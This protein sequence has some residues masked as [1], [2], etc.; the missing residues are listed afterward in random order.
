MK[1]I[2]LTGGN[3]F[4]GRNI[5]EQL[6]GEYNI[7]A[8]NSAELDLLDAG[9][10]AAYLKK[11]KVTDIIHAA[12]YNPKRRNVSREAELGA[13]LR[14]FYN[15]AQYTDD[16]DK[17]I[18]FGSGAE[19]DK[20]SPI[21]MAREDDFGKT[22]SVLNDY[23]LSKYLMNLEALRSKNIYNL[24]LFGVFGK[25]ENWQTCFIS[26]LCGKALYAL[27]LTIRQ[28]CVFDFL[29]VDDLMP[30]LKWM[31]ENTPNYHDYNVCSRKPVRLTEIAKFVS[32]I[33]G[34]SLEIIVL[35]DGMNLEYTGDNTRIMKEFQLEITE[36]DMAI[37]KLFDFYKDNLI[38]IDREEIKRC[39]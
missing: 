14:M 28:E 25:Y 21:H 2:L 12:V 38:K 27:P 20:R 8:P 31:L 3:G 11:Y 34:K 39:H 18:Y 37:K 9:A 36:L 23:S 17:M 16:L 13:N 33:S 26:N 7:F 5:S 4:I 32:M 10:V 30:P 19:F 1:N 22:I 6:S 24:R 35:T 29:Y 15:L